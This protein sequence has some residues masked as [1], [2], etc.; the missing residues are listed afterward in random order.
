M[1][2][3][4]VALYALGLGAM[5]LAGCTSQPGAPSNLPGAAAT[6]TDAAT[7]SRAGGPGI[8]GGV[9]VTSQDL[10]YD[11]F[12]TSASLPMRGKFQL[13]EDGVT[14]FGPG[15]PGYRGGRWWVDD[16]DVPGVQE[17]TD[18]FF[19]CPLLPPGRPA[20]TCGH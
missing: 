5:A 10:C 6:A 18:T 14:E 17:E 20:E 13:L 16:G 1:I 8:A 7:E 19:L 4:N 2:R 9:Y 3:E 15:D 12:A 11:T